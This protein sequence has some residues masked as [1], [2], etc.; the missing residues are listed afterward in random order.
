MDNQ[1][2][3]AEKPHD[4]TW[5]ELWSQLRENA[6]TKTALDAFTAVHLSA[7]DAEVASH[8]VYQET[9]AFL[10]AWQQHNYGSMSKTIT[11]SFRGVS[12]VDVRN[13]YQGH[14]LEDF[15]VLTLHH[16]AAAITTVT[17]RLRIDGAVHTP[18]L[19]WVRE[20]PDGRS[21]APNQP[22]EWRLM[23]WGYPYMTRD[24]TDN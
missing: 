23:W 19:R 1:R 20:G 17:V 11:N 22:G 3:E 12:P 6:E 5:R 18:E 10:R 15:E 4:P 13:D 24:S 14:N 2:R 7:N 9:T 16:S 21:A 8:P